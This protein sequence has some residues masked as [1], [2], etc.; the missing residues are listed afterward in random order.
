MFCPSPPAPQRLKQPTGKQAFLFYHLLD[1]ALLCQPP[2]QRGLDTHPLLS[3]PFLSRT[4]FPPVSHLPGGGDL[5]TLSSKI[6]EQFRHSNWSY[7]SRSGKAANIH[8]DDEQETCGHESWMW[9]GLL[10]HKRGESPHP[11][12]SLSPSHMGIPP[13]SGCCKYRWHKLTRSVS[14]V[15][16]GKLLPDPHPD[17]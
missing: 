16:L 11:S 3:G 7:T 8:G 6:L 10:L 9:L 13:A 14:S 15:L 4:G 17:P 5:P 2:G 1:S 12:V